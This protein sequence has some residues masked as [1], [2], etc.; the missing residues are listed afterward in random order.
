MTVRTGRDSKSSNEAE[1]ADTLSSLRRNDGM[2]YHR[3]LLFALVVMGCGLHAGCGSNSDARTQRN[4]G[5]ASAPAASPTPIVVNVIEALP[6]AAP[7]DLLVPASLSIENTAV[8]LAQRD[9]V[10]LQLEAAEGVRVA[11]GQTLARLDDDEQRAGLRQLEFEVSRLRI[12]EEQYKSL[13]NVNRNEL[14]RELTLAKD[15][16]TSKAEVERAQYRLDVAKAEYERTRLATK[17][18]QARVESSRLELAKSVVKAPRAGV[19]TRRH[20]SQG[21]GVV[22]GDKLFEIAELSPLT[23]KFQAPQAGAV[24]LSVGQVVTLSLADER[25]AARARVRRVDPVADAAS[26]TIGYLADVVAGAGLVPGLTVNVHV[27]RTSAVALIWIPRAA[28]PAGSEPRAGTTSTL[29][30]LESD[31]CAL[32]QV[33]VNAAVGDQVEISSG[34]VAGERVIMA[35]P[36]GLKAGDMVRAN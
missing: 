23:V 33:W 31:R 20:V 13:I 34:L 16:L 2:N 36:T 25:P 14:E 5:L 32:R 9:G 30:V 21:T 3:T 26:S 8:V 4:A 10:V 7:G 11:Q 6:V 22:K 35:P 1:D 12:E 17:G 24:R 18:A 19:V 28:F 29:F 15:G 27:P